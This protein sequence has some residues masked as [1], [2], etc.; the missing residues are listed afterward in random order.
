MGS[1][2]EREKLEKAFLASAAKLITDVTWE[3]NWSLTSGMFMFS[4]EADNTDRLFRSQ[5]FTDEDYPDR[6]LRFFLS[7]HATDSPRAIAM[8]IF[9][10]GEMQKDN[11]IVE[12]DLNRFPAIRAILENEDYVDF[13]LVYPRVRTVKYIVIREMPDDFYYDLVEVINRAY[14]YRLYIAVSVLTRKLLEN[15]LVDTMRKKFGMQNADLFYDTDSRRFHSFNVLVRNFRDHLSEFRP[16]MPSIDSDFVRKLNDFR[17]EGNS[18]AHT[19][20]AQV[21]ES[22]LVAR[23][24]DLEVVV[25][26]LVRLYKNI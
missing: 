23:K 19:L 4:Q 24:D 18:A 22:E 7:A 6:V 5:T 1:E 11:L 12:S 14:A 16:V 3:T 26:T 13:S 8:V 9:I 17:E 25:K 15:L 10:I 2:I 20:E 21:T